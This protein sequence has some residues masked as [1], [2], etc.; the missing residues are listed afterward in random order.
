MAISGILKLPKR[1]THDYQPSSQLHLRDTMDTVLLPVAAVELNSGCNKYADT[2]IERAAMQVPNRL[3]RG[4]RPVM[5]SRKE[6]PLILARIVISRYR[7]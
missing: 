6:Y 4:S 1:K 5:V 2:A 7:L 3:D